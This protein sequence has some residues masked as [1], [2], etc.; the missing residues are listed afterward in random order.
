MCQNMLSAPFTIFFL[1]SFFYLFYYSVLV[2]LNA[3][4]II[5]AVIGTYCMSW[6]TVK[7][8]Q[9]FISNIDHEIEISTI[10]LDA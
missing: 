9:E 5:N 3:R 7:F 2:V 10:C 8:D 4:R 1:I 6:Y